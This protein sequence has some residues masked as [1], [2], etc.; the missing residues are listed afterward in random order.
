VGWDDPR[1]KA[2]NKTGMGGTILMPN[3]VELIRL[4]GGVDAIP[5][6]RDGDGFLP[7]FTTDDP[8]HAVVQWERG[9]LGDQ[10]VSLKDVRTRRTYLRL[11]RGGHSLWADD[12]HQRDETLGLVF[13]IPLDWTATPWRLPFTSSFDRISASHDLDRLAAESLDHWIGVIRGAME[14]YIFVRRD[15]FIF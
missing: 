14:T 4:I 10:G 8:R 6:P 9:D 2:A 1:G 7:I 3:L 15:R 5:D 12:W 11:S 13:G